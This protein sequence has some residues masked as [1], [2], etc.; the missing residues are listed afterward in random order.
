M[1]KKRTTAYLPFLLTLVL[2][3]GILAGFYLHPEE[4][5]QVKSIFPLVQMKST[6]VEDVLQ[7]IQ[8]DY[9][10]S[11]DMNAIEEAAIIRMLEKLDPHSVYISAEEFLQV[12]ESLQGNFEG[13]GIQFRIENDTIVVIKTIP[14]GPSEKVGLMDGDRIVTINDSIVAGTGLVN[15]EAVKLLKGPKGSSVT[16]GIFRRGFDELLPFTI[17][18]DVI[19]TWSVDIA[20]LPN[21]STGYIKVNTFSVNTGDEF[22]A[23][24]K[25]LNRSE[26]KQL[27]LDLRGNTGGYLQAA[28]SMADEFLPEGQTIVYTE[29]LNRPR[30]YAMATG[31]G[32]FE[33][34]S[35]I[36]LI[37]EGSASASEIVAGAIQDNDRGTIVGRRSFGKG[38]VQEQHNLSDGSAIRLTVARYHTP[39]GR[40]IQKPYTEDPEAYFMEF[41]ERYANGELQSSD[42]IH[43]ADSLKYYTPEGKI[44]YGGGGI[45][46][47]VFV[48]IDPITENPF[49]YE[50]I[51]RG[52]LYQWAFKYTDTHRQ[53]LQQFNNSEEFITQFRLRDSEFNAMLQY[54]REL[55]M[56]V[57]ETEAL[58]V[59]PNLLALVK[60]YIARNLLD[61]AGFYPVYH[62]I[63]NG[64]I[65]AME[66]LSQP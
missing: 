63:D 24:L 1:N 19:P 4:K 2:S 32:L 48:P 62:T 57:P 29:G 18:R 33:T 14:K 6:K 36:I 30:R 42:S 31:K 52:L 58:K 66:T 9:V 41:Y 7:Y 55:G 39:T 60:A 10:D 23:A 22:S 64:F 45:M 38:L 20:Y 44:V 16:V 37:D 28:I 61:D 51:N 27:I 25:R 26:I 3:L 12:N 8:Q 49:Y 40:C 47:D 17:L 13:I 43:F 34:G 15:D 46:P 59:K 35:L 50:A 53:E 21:D 65:Q 5:S 56:E 11:V 54:C